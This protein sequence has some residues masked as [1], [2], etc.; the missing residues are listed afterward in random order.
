VE[1]LEERALGNGA[2]GVEMN[3]IPAGI[4]RQL[5]ARLPNATFSD[6]TPT[7]WKMRMVK[8]EREVARQRQAYSIA[9]RIYAE[10]IRTLRE[11]PGVTVG[12][13]RGLQMK[14]AVEAGCPPIHF[15]YVFPQDGKSKLAW[16]TGDPGVRVEKGDVVLLDLGLVYEGYTTDFGRNIV[17]GECSRTLKEVYGKTLELRS[18]I[19]SAIK[20]GVRA[21]DAHNAATAAYNKFGWDRPGSVGHGLGIECHEP[22]LLT[23][24]DETLLEEGMTIVIE[25]V[26]GADG[27]YFLLEDA[28]IVTKAG[29][30]S[31]TEM[32]PELVQ[33]TTDN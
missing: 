17:V 19:S 14:L 1:A 30:Q 4:L 33:L 15:G 27:I 25:L 29:W 18:L 6:A 28:G 23:A 2:I 3:H 7:L 9:E 21:C 11:K 12:E 22:P 32:S 24:D 31:L 8:T 20:P 13:I 10:V 26:T 16:Q 5:E